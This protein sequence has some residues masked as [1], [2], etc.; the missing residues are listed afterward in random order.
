V[1]FKGETLFCSECGREISEEDDCGYE[2]TPLC[3][4]CS[5]R[6][7]K[8]F[9]GTKCFFCKEPLGEDGDPWHNPNT[10]EYAHDNC[11]RAEDQ[12][13]I[14]DEEWYNIEECM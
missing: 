13:E 14:E 8:A 5:S 7:Y 1:K 12:D 3:S 2:D 11:I 4:G 6:L 10:D 9:I